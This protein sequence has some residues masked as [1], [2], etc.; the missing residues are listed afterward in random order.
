MLAHR[1]GTK[2]FRHPV[3][4]DLTLR[5]EALEIP[6]SVGLTLYGYTAEPRSPAEDGLKLLASWA[7][8]F[9]ESIGSPTAAAERDGNASNSRRQ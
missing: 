8:T 5:Y 6:G 1:S 4:G 9:P 7:A 2:R 3:I